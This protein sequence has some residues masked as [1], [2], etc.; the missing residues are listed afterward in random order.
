MLFGSR[1]RARASF[2]ALSDP[3]SLG[4]QTEQTRVPAG[5]QVNQESA[6]DEIG[7]RGL[8][9]AGSRAPWVKQHFH[10]VTLS[11]DCNCTDLHLHSTSR[12]RHEQG[13]S[14]RVPSYRPTSGRSPHPYSTAGS[15][16][17]RRQP[18]TTRDEEAQRQRQ[19]QEPTRS[20]WAGAIECG[21]CHRLR[22]AG[23]RS[24]KERNRA[25]RSQQAGHLLVTAGHMGNWP[26]TRITKRRA[27][28]KRTWLGHHPQITPI[29]RL[30]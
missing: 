3:I 15:A 18:V 14:I 28:T 11:R 26:I 5:A 4:S 10:N 30:W 25:A 16:G 17:V 2:G 6:E 21:L 20:A 1:I 24:P 9:V 29:L 7:K 13:P 23:G 19:D 8:R 12:A 22:Q 27:P